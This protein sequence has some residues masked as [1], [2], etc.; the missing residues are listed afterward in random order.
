[1]VSLETAH[2]WFSVW[3]H[4]L[5][6]EIFSLLGGEPSIHP[7]LPDFLRLARIHWPNSE[8]R[9]ITNGFFLHRHPD[10]PM[11]LRETE[12]LLA[13]SRHHSGPEYTE[14]FRP[15]EELARSWEREHRIRL[16]IRQ[17]EDRWTRR[18]LG[19]GTNMQ[20]YEDQ[21]PGDSWKICPAK[22]CLQLHLGKLWK[23]PALAYLGMQQAKYNL[24]EKWQPYLQYQPLDSGCTD[25][26]LQAFVARQAES[27]CGMCPS[28][29]QPFV[30]PSPLPVS[31]AQSRAA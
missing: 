10:L 21:R 26:E 14:K 19:P 28:V 9:L 11:T 24:S 17:A 18:Y 22:L 2:D 7:Q 27:F 12:T 3:S 23:C 20:P 13:I 25:A 8:L 15:I 4:R 1:M 31:S 30:L 16:E 6:P 5:E 29:P